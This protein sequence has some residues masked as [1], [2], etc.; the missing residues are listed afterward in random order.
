[1]EAS[2]ES[3]NIHHS[4]CDIEYGDINAAIFFVALGIV[5][6]VFTY[7][8]FEVEVRYDSECS[9]STCD[10]SFEIQEQIN[11]PIYFYYGL[12]NFNQNQRFYAISKSEAQ[13]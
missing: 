3:I 10:I 7:K 8:E 11:P 9:G 6:F 5:I 2:A 13:I 4:V 1:M 12:T